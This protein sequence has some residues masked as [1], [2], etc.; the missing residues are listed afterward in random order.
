MAVDGEEDASVL[1]DIVGKDAVDLVQPNNNLLG[2]SFSSHQSATST[3]GSEFDSNLED[4]KLIGNQVGDSRL[5]GRHAASMS[6]SAE[7]AIYTTKMRRCAFP[8]HYQG[9]QYFHCKQSTQGAWCAT[10]VDEALT[11]TEW[12][13]CVTN[14]HALALAKRAAMTAAKIE[15]KRVLS[16]T[17]AKITPDALR[18]ALRAAAAA[19]KTPV[20]ASKSSAGT[21][22]GAL[23]HAPKVMGKLEAVDKIDGMIAADRKKK[24]SFSEK[25][26][27]FTTPTAPSAADVSY[28]TRARLPSS[29]AAAT[30]TTDAAAH[31]F[32]KDSQPA[33]ISQDEYPKKGTSEALLSADDDTS[34]DAEDG[35][36]DPEV[37]REE[38]LRQAQMA[39][40]EEYQAEQAAKDT[41][42]E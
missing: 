33:A 13:Y 1:I 38:E 31:S 32:S 24:K 26:Q 19:E 5:L 41:R 36:F 3:T 8:F 29:V 10:K 39:D 21:P 27:H 22:P 28:R 15:I 17:G 12:D 16:A 23:A 30:A 35:S 4:D 7:D 37:F 42:A 11:V 20:Q 6:N 2:D 25:E 9:Q 18:E 14:K 34:S 40:L